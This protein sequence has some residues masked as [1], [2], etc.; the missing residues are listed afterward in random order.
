M[1]KSGARFEPVFQKG[2][3]T[4]VPGQEFHGDRPSERADVQPAKKWAAASKQPAEDDPQ[5][6]KHVEAEED[7][8]EKEVE[9]NVL[10]AFLRATPLV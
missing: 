1:A 6:P 2:Q 10:F 3:R 5:T 8:S 4:N 9:R 7:V